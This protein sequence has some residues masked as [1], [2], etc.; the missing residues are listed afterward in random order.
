VN[1]STDGGQRPIEAAAQRLLPATA[2]TF[3]DLGAEPANALTTVLV[4]WVANVRW[5]Q[6]RAAEVV[7]VI[8]ALRAGGAV[9]DDRDRQ[10][11]AEGGV[12]TVVSALDA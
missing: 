3:L 10:L 2:T 6:Y 9:V 5:A 4:W 7:D 11:A 8:E 12:P 1:A